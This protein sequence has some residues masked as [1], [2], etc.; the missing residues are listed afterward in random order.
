MTARTTPAGLQVAN[1]P[2]PASFANGIAGG[3]IGRCPP[4]TADQTV[5]LAANEVTVTGSSTGGITIGP[6]RL[7][8]LSWIAG[9]AMSSGVGNRVMFRFK[10]SATVIMEQP[11]AAASG[12]TQ[13]AEMWTWITPTQGSHTYAMTI[14]SI[15]AGNATLKASA[16]APAMFL[17]EDLGPAS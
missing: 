11:F 2:A 14:Q 3:W 12:V 8:K 15:D 7:I 4:I 6:N 17:V 9:Y 10:E 13:C 1:T 16:A 5:T